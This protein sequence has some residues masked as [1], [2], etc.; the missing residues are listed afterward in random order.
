MS[1]SAARSPRRGGARSSTREIVR[2]DRVRGMAERQAELVH[3]GVVYDL[4]VDTT[5][6]EALDCARTIARTL[7]T[8]VLS[9]SR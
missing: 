2:G 8:T 4:E 1:S 5:H 6:S 9:G 7:A 3:L